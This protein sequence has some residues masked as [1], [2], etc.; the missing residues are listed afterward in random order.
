MGFFSRRAER[1]GGI[2]GGRAGKT[3]PHVHNP[4]DT[5]VQQCTSCFPTSDLL[6][7]QAPPMHNH[8]PK[9]TLQL[10]VNFCAHHPSGFLHCPQP[11]PASP[12]R[13]RLGCPLARLALQA[14]APSGGSPAGCPFPSPASGR[15]RLLRAR[16]RLRARRCPGSGRCAKAASLPSSSSCAPPAGG[17]GGHSAAGPGSADFN[18]QHALPGAGAL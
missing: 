4:N 14:A 12:Q 2:V 3:H 10:C 5:H 8:T 7:R 15:R 16:T 1:G 11:Q 17:A 9:D 6:S 13:L 18:S